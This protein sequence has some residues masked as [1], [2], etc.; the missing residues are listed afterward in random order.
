MGAVGGE[1]V[2]RE[3]HDDMSSVSGASFKFNMKNFSD[4]ASPNNQQK[5]IN[6]ET[7]PE[8]K[9]SKSQPSTQREKPITKKP[10][11]DSIS[12]KQSKEKKKFFSL[13]LF[14]KKKVK[15]K[16]VQVEEGFPQMINSNNNDLIFLK[17]RIL[18]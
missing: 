11:T 8:V 5:M 13:K 2:G 14:S 16:V 4:P 12:T 10:S 15:R 9:R 1:F 7:P 6:S 3:M 17:K 18:C